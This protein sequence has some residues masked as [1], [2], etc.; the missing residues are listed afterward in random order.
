MVPIVY[1][2]FIRLCHSRAEGE[3]CQ[4]VGCL[5]SDFGTVEEVGEKS[6]DPD[7]ICYSM[8]GCNGG[9]IFRQVFSAEVVASVRA[10]RWGVGGCR[11]KGPSSFFL[12]FVNYCWWH[13]D[14]KG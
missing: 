5:V 10:W 12:L 3:C 11:K 8:A 9:S 2:L 1:S 6:R 13:A 7:K 4:A 14:A